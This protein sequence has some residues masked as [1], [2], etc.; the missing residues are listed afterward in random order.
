MEIS[1]EIEKLKTESRKEAC[2]VI[3]GLIDR[4]WISSKASKSVI[5]AMI[6]EQPETP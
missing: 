1:N 2:D 6:N 5:H 4:G 3:D